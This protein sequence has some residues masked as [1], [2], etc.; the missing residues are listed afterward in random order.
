[1]Y[2]G[3]RSVIGLYDNEMNMEYSSNLKNKMI[4]I[5]AKKEREKTLKTFIYIRLCLTT[6]DT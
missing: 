3:E 5:E 1:M 4:T 2:D 6:R